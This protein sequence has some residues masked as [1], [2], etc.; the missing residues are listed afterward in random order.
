MELTRY[1]VE[2]KQ[3]GAPTFLRLGC[4]VTAYGKADALT[5]LQQALGGELPAIERIA[6]D[7][8]VRTLDQSHVVPNMGVPNERGVWFPML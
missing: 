6:E 8:D 7:I 3:E 4:G 1:W 2:F 5:L